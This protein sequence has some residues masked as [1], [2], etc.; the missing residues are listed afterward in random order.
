[1][2]AITK[3]KRKISDEIIDNNNLT[4]K[5]NFK[6]S[7]KIPKINLSANLFNSENSNQLQFQFDLDSQK[8]YNFNKL[9]KL[10]FIDL[11]AGIGGIRI[12]LENA[13]FEISHLSDSKT[14]FEIQENFQSL[15]SND[16]LQQ[17]KNSIIDKL[18]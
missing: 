3:N 17:Y 2:K 12:A 5:S 14:N 4:I 15:M 13:G 9:E 16:S 8:K 18:L 11:F 10:K 1:M 7:K 6:D